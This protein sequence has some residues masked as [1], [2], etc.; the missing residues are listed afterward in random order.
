[1]FAKFEDYKVMLIFLAFSLPFLHFF[2]HFCFMK[3]TAHG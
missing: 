1:M 2:I 3:F